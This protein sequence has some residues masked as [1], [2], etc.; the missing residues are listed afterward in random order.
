[1]LTVTDIHQWLEQQVGR[2]LS[3][4]EGVM[5]GDVHR[6]IHHVSVTWMPSPG[7]IR[8]AADAG[9]DLLIHHEALLYPYPFQDG[10][11]AD[12]LRWNVN[13]LRMTA[14]AETGLT[15]T[16]LHGTLDEL[17]IF[18]TF[19]EQL[20]LRDPC[21]C[22]S[23]YCQRVFQIEPTPYAELIEK[24]KRAVGLTAVRT[25]HLQPDRLVRRVGVPWGGLGLLVNVGYQ[26]QLLDLCHDIDV[27]IMG[28]T[29][30]YGFRFSTELGID[31]IECSHELSENRGL[32]RFS[33]MLADAFPG[34]T[35]QFI[36][37]PCVWRA[38]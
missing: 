22:G 13:R 11:P 18:E 36:D 24:V 7:N 27:M 19:T 23:D 5:Y 28:E 21:K 6:P 17:C 34:L 20:G 15:A 4:D 14:L 1:M 2:P 3:S 12:A 26:Q 9:S 8:D 30:S 35:V 31:V 38:S 32:Q 29:D 37:E 25:T 33:E 16:R 10:I